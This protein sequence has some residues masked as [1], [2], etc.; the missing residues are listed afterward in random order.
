[1]EKFKKLNEYRIKT[2]L[3]SIGDFVTEYMTSEEKI[4]FWNNHKKYC[5]QL[6][7]E[8]KLGKEVEQILLVEHNPFFDDLK[9]INAPIVFSH[10]IVILDLN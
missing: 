1:M 2:K 4:A 8:G 7:K 3:G 10:R 9:V 5:E 6:E